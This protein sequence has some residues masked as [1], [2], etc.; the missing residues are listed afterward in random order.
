MT[1]R[2]ARPDGHWQHAEQCRFQHGLTEPGWR[3]TGNVHWHWVAR[4]WPA[5]PPKLAGEDDDLYIARLTGQDGTNRVPYDHRRCGHC[6]IGLH[7]QLCYMPCQCPCRSEVGVLE[8]QVYQLQESLVAAYSVAWGRTR[9]WGDLNA[10]QRHATLM[11][12]LQSE[13]W[14]ILKGRPELADWY[15]EPVQPVAT[16]SAAVWYR[17]R[18][19]DAHTA[20]V[21]VETETGGLIEPLPHIVKHSP[22]GFSWGFG[23]S[24]PAELARCLLIHALGGEARCPQCNG[25]GHIVWMLDVQDPRPFVPGEDLPVGA[26]VDDCISC[27]GGYRMLPYQQFKSEV[28]ATWPEE[29]DWQISST[30]IR[31]W[32]LAHN[33]D[34]GQDAAQ[35]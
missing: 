26:L 23:G 6:A 27:E 4:Y 29:G 32:W 21:T 3:N 5:P 8:L 17:G 12:Q 24:G 22:T 14:E 13:A 15:L 1:G 11:M 10:Q 9:A 18:M 35:A 33:E 7:D 19:A 2:H 16:V 34:G 25:S 28:V 30:E 20:V 31:A